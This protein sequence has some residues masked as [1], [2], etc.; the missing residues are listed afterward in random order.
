MTLSSVPALIK[1]LM[2]STQN[3]AVDY[4]AAAAQQ[5]RRLR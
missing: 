2:K 1:W 4:Q 3:A 5:W